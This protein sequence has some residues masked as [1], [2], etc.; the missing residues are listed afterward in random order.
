MA[1]RKFNWRAIKAHSV[2]TFDEASTLLRCA[3]KTLRHIIQEEQVP[4]ADDVAP[5]LVL[6]S[7]L[8]PALRSRSKRQH[9]K[10]GQMFCLGCKAPRYPAGGMVDDIGSPPLPPLLQGLCSCCGSLMG[11]R[12]SGSGKEAFLLAASRAL[13][14]PN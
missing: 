7:D 9:L 3:S 12:V 5:V 11:R 6:G 10:P 1:G 14:S 4:V 2:Y 8:I 13:N